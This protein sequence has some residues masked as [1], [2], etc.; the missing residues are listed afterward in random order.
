MRLPFIV[1]LFSTFLCGIVAPG[2]LQASGAVTWGDFITSMPVAGVTTTVSLGGGSSVDV[3]VST[4][5]TQG[6]SAADFGATG[7]TATGL[8]YQ[9][10]IAFGIFNGGGSG[11]V[12][13]T[14]LFTNFHAGPG[15]V[16]GYLM[17]AAVNGQSSPITLSSSVPGAVQTWTQCGE[18]FDLNPDNTWPISWAPASGQLTTDAPVGIDSDGIVI[19]VGSI[20]Q[21][22]SVTITLQQY[23]NDGII[24]SIGEE[25]GFAT[26]V[27]ERPQRL[28]TWGR[29]KSLM[30]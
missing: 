30:R 20:A 18:T 6:I 22:A 8:D 28:L 19:R 24:F 5:G 7:A 10:L 25:V 12:T 9:H 4:G 21:C 13:T 11:T 23:L 15:H 26:S 27:P 14:I 29:I 16:S 17:V 2:E 1:A 3:L